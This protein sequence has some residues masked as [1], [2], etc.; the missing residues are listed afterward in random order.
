[1]SKYDPSTPRPHIILAVSL[2]GVT[3]RT[4]SCT[5]TAFVAV[6]VTENSKYESKS[7]RPEMLMVRPPPCSTACHVAV[8][9]VCVSS[10]VGDV[11]CI[12]D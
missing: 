12:F 10:F 4:M 3:R 8:D 11:T 7:I 6:T 5:V 9:G 1:M 2:V